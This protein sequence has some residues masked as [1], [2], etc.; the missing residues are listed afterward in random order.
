MLAPQAAG[1]FPE[2]VELSPVVMRLLDDSVTTD[3]QR[4]ALALFHGQWDR[5][6][7]PTP[8]ERAQMA[9]Y[10]YD[11]T[12]PDLLN[13]DASPLIRGRALWLQGDAAAA[14]TML[15][16]E[17][18]AQA[19]LV[20]SLALEQL[21]KTGEAIAMLET[22]RDR[23]QIQTLADAAELTAAA[24]VIVTLA[25]L[26]GRP[27]QDYHLAMSLLGKVH[28]DLDPLYWPAFIAEAELLMDK[29]NGPEAAVALQEALHLNP[30]CSRAWYLLGQLAING[31]DFDLAN[32]C[33]SEMRKIRSDHLLADL[34][35]AE[36]L[37]TQKDPEAAMRVLEMA[38]ERYPQNVLLLALIAAAEAMGFDF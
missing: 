31:Y 16:D 38:L 11:L 6:E 17:S 33:R 28:G 10:R 27:A 34:L 29:D 36:T 14:I 20:K 18:S 2:Q 9:L 1:Q 19:I 26:Q 8:S 21:G 22:L 25:R 13:A 35:E 30:S 37:L 12:N 32:R 23:L 24:Q 7:D 3:S 4:R 5:L 15:E